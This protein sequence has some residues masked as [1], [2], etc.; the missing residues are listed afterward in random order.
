MS[1]SY[2]GVHFPL[3]TI[4]E[5]KNYMGQHI[6][7]QNHQLDILLQKFNETPPTQ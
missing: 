4:I 1:G 5:L 6:N 3:H 7:Q 2:T